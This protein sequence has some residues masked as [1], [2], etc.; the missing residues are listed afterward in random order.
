MISIIAAPFGVLGIDYVTALN[1]M[2]CTPD[3]TRRILSSFRAL[4]V[5]TIENSFYGV[6][7]GNLIVGGGVF[8]LHTAVLIIVKYARH[9]T[10]LEAATICWYPGITFAVLV[11][12]FVGTS[13]ATL[14]GFTFKDGSTLALSVVM[15]VVFICCFVVALFLAVIKAA[16]HY[17]P[18]EDVMD[19][20]VKPPGKATVRRFCNTWP[21]RVRGVWLPYEVSDRLFIVLFNLRRCRVTWVTLWLWAP[22]IVALFAAFPVNTAASC[23]AADV[24]LMVCHIFLFFLVARYRPLVSPID[25]IYF[26]VVM[27]V[28][29]WIL[30]GCIALLL[31]PDNS[32]A[33][34]AVSAAAVVAI[35]AFFLYLILK[36]LQVVELM[37][38]RIKRRKDGSA[39]NIEPVAV[40]SDPAV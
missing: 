9:K 20:A 6:M 33:V 29:V 16:V 23:I 4:S 14:Q 8:L 2:P 13:F 7:L 38:R 19:V 27:A 25:N 12:L 17:V 18:V 1:M 15:L 34:D 32:R 10:L 5:T 11:N 36:V 3:G 35:I 28:S 40:N 21:L 30:G 39:T 31:K 37:T 24:A 22:L 26:L